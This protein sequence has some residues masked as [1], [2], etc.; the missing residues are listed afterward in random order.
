MKFARL[1]WAGFALAFLSTVAAAQQAA[2]DQPSSTQQPL[3]D[4]SLSQPP[5][6]QAAP[7]QWTP[8]PTYVPTSPPPFQRFGP[9]PR[10][11]HHSPVHARRHHVR[12]RHHVVALRRHRAGRHQAMR[13]HHRVRHEHA[14]KHHHRIRHRQKVTRPHKIR[15]HHRRR[16]R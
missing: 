4:V 12:V 15:H 2:P 14:V 1:V 8:P 11:R 5:S 16:A 7:E 6:S 10:T 3:P 13:Q 9:G